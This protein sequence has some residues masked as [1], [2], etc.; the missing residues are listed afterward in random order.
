[1][2]SLREFYRNTC[3]ESKNNLERL[4]DTIEFDEPHDPCSIDT[5]IHYSFDFAQQIHIP[6]SP[7]QPGPIYFKTP[8]KC[9]IFGLM[10]E[11][12]PQQ[13]N[14]LTDEASDFGKG[15]NG[16]II[17]L[18]FQKRNLAK[19]TSKSTALLLSDLFCCWNTLP[20]YHPQ[21]FQLR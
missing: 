13:V 20:P 9:G 19:F 5:V 17:I 10:C 21:Y 8:H 7:M 3:S 2:K 4:A 16:T 6:S 11:A 15:A 1:M 18:D 12:V 14:Y